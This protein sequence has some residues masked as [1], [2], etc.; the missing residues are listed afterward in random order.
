MKLTTRRVVAAGALIG[1]LGLGGA[2]YAYAQTGSSP[3]TTTPR[4]TAPNPNSGGSGGAPDHPGNCP[5]M[6]NATQSS[7]MQM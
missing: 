6:G 5:N 2:G 3:S 1:A 4:T 7:S